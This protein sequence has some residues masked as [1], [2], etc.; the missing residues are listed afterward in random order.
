MQLQFEATGQPARQFEEF[1]YSTRKSWS[2]ERRVVGK[3]EWLP[4]KPNPRFVVTSLPTEDYDARTLYET[5]YCARG[6]MEN[7]IKE[8]Q[9]ALFFHVFPDYGVSLDGMAAGEGV[10]A[11]WGSARGIREGPPFRRRIT[12]I[13]GCRRTGR[14][15]P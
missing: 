6:D 5:I 13:P 10:V 7:R 1:T 9:L 2:R 12:D 3:A 8:Q 15:S 11:C 4:G 14:G